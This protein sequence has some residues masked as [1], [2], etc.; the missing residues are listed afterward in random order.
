VAQRRT[1][2]RVDGARGRPSTVGGRPTEL[3]RRIAFGEPIPMITFN[4]A[5]QARETIQQ[6]IYQLFG[7]PS[8]HI[9]RSMMR[10]PSSTVCRL[11]GHQY[12]RR[13]R[14]PVAGP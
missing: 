4:L 7:S 6:N 13:E 8:Q 3:T 5:E 10:Q 1:A 14:A 11:P 9:S 12:A 2:R